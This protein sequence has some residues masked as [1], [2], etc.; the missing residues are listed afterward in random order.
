MAMNPKRP[1]RGPF[2]PAPAPIAAKEPAPVTLAEEISGDETD[3][4]EP[5]ASVAPPSVEPRAVIMAES[6]PAQAAARAE[7][8]PE[9]FDATAWPLMTLDI[10]NEN[11]VALMGFAEEF[12]KAKSADEVMAAQSRFASERY[13]SCLR[14]S[15][16]LMD[17]AQ[18]LATAAAAPLRMGFAT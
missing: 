6:A 14:Q 11:A 7:A 17:L 16:E 10:W 12:G 5:A 1:G 18:R 3:A 4:I 2:K 8:P 15:K 9:R 13:E